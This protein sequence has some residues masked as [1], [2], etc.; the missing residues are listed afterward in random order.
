MCYAIRE[1]IEPLTGCAYVRILY[2][3]KHSAYDDF[4]RQQ[5]GDEANMRYRATA[6]KL[7]TVCARTR[8]RIVYV[9]EDTRAETHATISYS[10][11]AVSLRSVLRRRDDKGAG[12][13]LFVPGTMSVY[14]RLSA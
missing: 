2:C 14:R 3:R 10:H 11:R 8:A 5:R 12:N 13:S 9:C 1:E 4:P 7:T 6:K